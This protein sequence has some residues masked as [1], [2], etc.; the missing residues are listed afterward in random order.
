MI[1]LKLA[2]IIQSVLGRTLTQEKG[3]TVTNTMTFK[4]MRDRIIAINRERDRLNVQKETLVNQLREQCAHDIV[5]ETPYED[6][7]L[8]RRICVTCALEEDGWGSGYKILVKAPIKNNL[9]RDEFYSYRKFVPLKQI[10]IPE[11][12]V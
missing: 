1:Y 4:E 11:N 10:T 8:P 3:D 9:S 6:T 7:M 5:M 2:G 12:L